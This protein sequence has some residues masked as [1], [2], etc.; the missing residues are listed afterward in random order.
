MEFRPQR[1]LATYSRSDFR[2]W[3]SDKKC[4]EQRLGGAAA[5]C[6]AGVATVPRFTPGETTGVGEEPGGVGDEGGEPALCYGGEREKRTGKPLGSMTTSVDRAVEPGGGKRRAGTAGTVKPWLGLPA[7]EDLVRLAGAMVASG[8]F[9][10]HVP[11][12]RRGATTVEATTGG[13]EAA[14]ARAQKSWP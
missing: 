14:G 3:L 7:A 4:R 12:A 9:L 8:P 6:R 11:Q 2:S 10:G 5:T 1:N 13:C